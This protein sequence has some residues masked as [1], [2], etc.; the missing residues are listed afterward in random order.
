MDMNMSNY[1]DGDLSLNTE[2]VLINSSLTTSDEIGCQHPPTDRHSR[3]S[4]PEQISIQRWEY[5]DSDDNLSEQTDLSVGVDTK[6]GN[7]DGLLLR[8]A[9]EDGGSDANHSGDGNMTDG[10]HSVRE[11]AGVRDSTIVIHAG[12]FSSI[13]TVELHF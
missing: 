1:S 8:I 6:D 11:T 4:F 13:T 12:G 7:G 2:V 5:L 3:V 10:A 9:N